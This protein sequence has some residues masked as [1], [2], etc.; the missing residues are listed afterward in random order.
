MG[1]YL[2]FTYGSQFSG[3]K[4]DLKIRYL[5]AEIFAKQN[6]ILV[7]DDSDQN[8]KFFDLEL[9]YILKMIKIKTITSRTE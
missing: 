1:L 4:N 7:L 8:S 3:E 5:V 2:E 6:G 9:P